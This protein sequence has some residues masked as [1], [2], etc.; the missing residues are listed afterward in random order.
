MAEAEKLLGYAFNYI[1]DIGSGQQF[2]ITGSLPLEATRE[3]IDAEFMK[4]RH[5]IEKQKRISLVVNLEEGIA[6]HERTIDGYKKQLA[7]L[8]VERGNRPVA[9]NERGAREQI[10]AN[11]ENDA[12]MLKHKRELLAK[13]KKDME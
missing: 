11:I 9:N 12:A 10:A 8:D 7:R 4:F 1:A 2:Q 6:Q 13:C 5:N 3:Q